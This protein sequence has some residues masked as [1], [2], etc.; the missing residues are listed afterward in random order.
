MGK[1]IRWYFHV[2]GA[3][4]AYDIWAGPKERDARRAIREFYG[5]KRLPPNLSIWKAGRQL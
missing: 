3:M 4:Y 2:P 5:V 1:M